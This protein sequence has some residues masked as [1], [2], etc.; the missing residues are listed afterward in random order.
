MRTEPPLLSSCF[1]D[2]RVAH[3]RQKPDENGQ[4]TPQP[5]LCDISGSC[6]LEELS[7]QPPGEAETSQGREDIWGGG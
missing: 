4:K 6:S 2:F 5:S 1:L 3:R 7:D